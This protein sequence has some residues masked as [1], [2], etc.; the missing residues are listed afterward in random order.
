MVSHC[1]ICDGQLDAVTKV[2]GSVRGNSVCVCNQCGI[3]Q[4]VTS[5]DYNPKLDPHSLQFSGDRHISA[6]E[7]A[8][9]GNIRHGKGLRLDAHKSILT[10]V[11]NEKCPVKI[12]DDGANRGHF[13]RFVTGWSNEVEYIGCEPD[14]ICFESYQNN[15][16]PKI[17]NCYTEGFDLGSGNIDFIYS[18]H[19]L[20]HVDSVQGHLKLI[21]DG[22]RTG[23]TLFLDL[24]NTEQINFEQRIFEEYFVEKHKTHFFLFD[25]LKM[26]TF[27][28]M[29]IEF[30]TSDPFNM[31][32]VSSKTSNEKMIYNK[33]QVASDI[34]ER[35]KSQIRNYFKK[36]ENSK[37][38]FNKICQN[39]N[40]YKENNSVVFYG[41]GRLLLGFLSMG[42]TGQNVKTV[43][44]N[45][46]FD[47]LEDCGG[48]LL[49]QDNVLADV[50][51]STPIVIFARSSIPS[52]KD[53]LNKKGFVN[54]R[55]YSEFI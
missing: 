51:K 42:L 19:T 50:D 17:E 4:S 41:G 27:H 40:S 47:K 13:A 45:Y 18:A 44:D 37:E 7:G 5:A 11:L 26:L 34:L 53:D 54:I 39:L 28:G 32:V 15:N 20:E 43:I 6:S 29:D 48:L 46:L 9:W 12:F 52:I 1:S 35:R 49:H 2:P 33:F 3:I 31:T 22:L 14:P 16:T 10:R 55:L 30:V 8:M 21:V 36:S 24:P 23:G 25:V 38:T